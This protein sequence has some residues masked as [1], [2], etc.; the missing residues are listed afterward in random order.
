MAFWKKAG[1]R[2]QWFDADGGFDLAFRER[3]LGL[4]MEVAARGH[5]GWL[6][7]PEGA[8]ALLILTDQFPRNAFRGTGHMYATDPLARCFARQ[9]L[10]MGHMARVEPGLRLFFCLPFAHSED[11]DDQDLS[12]RLNAELGEPWLGHAEGH[13]D[14]I[15]RF[16]RFP[17]RNPVLGRAMTRQEDDYLKSGGF[18]G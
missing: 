18:R 13:R 9:A 7:S 10:A 12:V 11:L 5:D 2:G 15:R 8:L 16:G 17:H 3:C 4:H 14:I 6:A 1:E